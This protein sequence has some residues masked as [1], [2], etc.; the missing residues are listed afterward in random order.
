MKWQAWE[1]AHFGAAA[2]S[3]VFQRLLKRILFHTEADPARVEEAETN[4][5]RFAAV[6]DGGTLARGARRATGLARVPLPM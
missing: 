5:K 6:L 3:L 4:F 2:R 1:L